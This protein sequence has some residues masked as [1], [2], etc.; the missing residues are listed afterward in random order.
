MILAWAIAVNLFRH[1]NDINLKCR[2][3]ENLLK[4]KNVRAFLAHE[5][6]ERR[7]SFIA[8]HIS[9]IVISILN[10]PIY[11]KT[12]RH[13]TPLL[14]K[15]MRYFSKIFGNTF[16]EFRF[17]SFLNPITADDKAMTAGISSLMVRIHRHF[18]FGVAIKCTLTYVKCRT[19]RGKRSPR[20][21]LNPSCYKWVFVSGKRYA[22]GMAVN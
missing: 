4:E 17:A 5:K 19:D 1:G 22:Q 11:M 6:K 13:A 14:C 2:L 18:G 7:E 12:L 3:R 8:P 9:R 15:S 10:L 16:T 20:S 21:G